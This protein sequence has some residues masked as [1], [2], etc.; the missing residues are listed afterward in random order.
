[1]TPF[2]SLRTSEGGV[3]IQEHSLSE[4]TR[5][6][7]L[8]KYQLILYRNGYDETCN[9]KNDMQKNKIDDANNTSYIKSIFV[10]IFE[11]RFLCLHCV[12]YCL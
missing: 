4:H 7:D 11:G 8:T 12:F 5:M 9:A 1:M 2:L 3:A 10:S 6:I